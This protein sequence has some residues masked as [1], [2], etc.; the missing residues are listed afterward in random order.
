MRLNM[1][2]IIALLSL[3]TIMPAFAAAEVTRV[4]ITSRRDVLGGRSFGSTGPYE[5]IV[6]KIHFAVS[7]RTPRNAMVVDIDKAPRNGA[8]LVELSADL[9]IL[10]PKEQGRGNNV[11][12]VDI[13]NRGRRTVLTS[14]NRA[15]AGGGNGAELSTEAE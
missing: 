8:G 11:A 1:K 5:L 9:S 7:P 10:R 13:V 4:E 15:A 2:R 6:G 14:F 12:L 3:L